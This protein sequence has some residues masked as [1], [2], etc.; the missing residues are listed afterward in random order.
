MGIPC[1][2]FV[3]LIGDLNTKVWNDTADTNAW[4]VTKAGD[5]HDNNCK[6]LIQYCQANNLLTGGTELIHHSSQATWE[7]PDKKAEN[8]NWACHRQRKLDQF[9]DWRR[10]VGSYCDAGISNN[11]HLVIAKQSYR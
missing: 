1:H 3:L 10:D 8:P 2:D 6:W 7:I 4:R 5:K 9:A 11:S